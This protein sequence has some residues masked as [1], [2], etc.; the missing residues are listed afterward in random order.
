MVEKDPPQSE[1]AT[2][3]DAEV[4]VGSRQPRLNCVDRSFRRLNSIV[5]L[6]ACPACVHALIGSRPTRYSD[7]AGLPPIERTSDRLGCTPRLPDGWIFFPYPVAT[8]IVRVAGIAVF[9]GRLPDFIAGD[10]DQKLL[11]HF[12]EAGTAIL[13][14]KHFDYDGHH[15]TS[16]DHYR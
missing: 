3:I 8:L 14:V 5:H 1:A 6:F 13:A 16:L 10:R 2:D 7:A 9:R 11:P 4:A 15:R 12:G